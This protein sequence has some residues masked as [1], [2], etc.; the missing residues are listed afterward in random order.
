MK[1][2]YEKM[3]D[4]RN[5]KNIIEL[6]NSIEYLALYPMSDEEC[7]DDDILKHGGAILRCKTCFVLFKDKAKKVTPC[8]AAANYPLIVQAYVLASI[9]AQK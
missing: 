1:E 2:C 3:K 5:V 8:R 6:V 7:N 4:W 9:L